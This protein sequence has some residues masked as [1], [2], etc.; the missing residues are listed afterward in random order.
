MACDQSEWQF[1]EGDLGAPDVQGLLAMHFEAMR[2]SSP[3]EAC[4]VLPLDA[5]RSRDITFWSLREKGRLLCVGA[6]KRLDDRHGEIKSMRTDPASTGRGAGRMMLDHIVAEARRRGYAR[7]SL[8]TGSTAEF[9]AAIRLY[10]RNGF[11][12]SGPFAEYRPTRFTRFYTRA[13]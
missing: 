7:L 10:E 6:L 2:A 4:H 13:L 5:L 12:P 11:V 1:V 3:P 8:E 9:Q